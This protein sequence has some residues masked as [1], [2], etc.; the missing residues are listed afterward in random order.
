MGT[1]RSSHGASIYLQNFAVCERQGFV[2]FLFLLMERSLHAFP[3]S[4]T[5]GNGL[6]IHDNKDMVTKD[7]P[8]KRKQVVQKERSECHT[9]DLT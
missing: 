9:P 5:E 3:A 7:L 8:K 4:P 1:D 2:V 6:I